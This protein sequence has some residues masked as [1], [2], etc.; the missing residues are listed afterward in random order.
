MARELSHGARLAVTAVWALLI[1]LAVV[2]PARADILGLTID[3]TGIVLRDGSARVTGTVQCT[4]PAVRL[5]VSVSQ[6]LPGRDRS[7]GTLVGFTIPT[8]GGV[9]AWFSINGPAG[10]NLHFHEGTVLVEVF[11]FETFGVTRQAQSQV[12]LDRP[13]RGP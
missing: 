13:H 9:D 4:G 3:P 12:V 2:T 1:W 7:F 11:A 5:T 8:S 6:V 10:P